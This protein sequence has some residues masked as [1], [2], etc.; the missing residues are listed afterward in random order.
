MKIDKRKNQKEKVKGLATLK[1]GLTV[2]KVADLREIGKKLGIKNLS[3]LKKAELI[4][5]LAEEIPNYLRT[6]ISEY[7]ERRIFLLKRI[8]ANNGI[9]SEE[10][11]EIEE[12]EYFPKTGFM[13]IVYHNRNPFVT[14]P[15][16]I[17]PSLEE[18]VQ[19]SAI[20]TDVKRNTEWIKITR[21]LVYYYGTI[22]ANQL[23]ELVEKYI[24]IHPNVPAFNR[25]ILDAMEYYQEVHYDRYGYSYWEVLE[26]AE[27]L[28]EQALRKNIAY[29]PFTKKQLLEAGETNYLERPK[30]YSQLMELFTE[31]YQI[32]KDEAK[33]II[34]DCIIHV[35]LNERPSQI[36][37]Y[38]QLELPLESL[39]EVKRLMDI[40]V[41]F[42]NNTRQWY[43]KGYTPVELS[44]RDK[45]ASPPL[46]SQKGEVISFQTRE[47]IGRN[48]PCPCG[49]GKKY[50]KCCGK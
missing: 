38:L 27:I 39:E 17:L 41:V 3:S 43:L 28:A 40:I 2:Y 47:K 26:P 11:V 12:M 36:L 18:I 15:V 16:E 21:G 6:I 49:S 32:P 23:I 31:V 4:S 46:S 45:Q 25:V 48:D 37:Q 22:P 42:M 35:K 29:Y 30:G 10:D 50:K 5:Y 14:I 19:D 20:L 9:I 1:E 24:P 13:F 7:D 33:A 44:G 8:I 34:D